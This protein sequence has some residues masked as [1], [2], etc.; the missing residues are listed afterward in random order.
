MRFVPLLGLA[1]QFAI[2]GLCLAQQPCKSTVVGDLRISHFDSKIYGR[3][4]TL[5]IWLPPGYG[6]SGNAAHKYPTLYL[7]DGQT[8]FDDCTAF[9][10]E[11]ELQVDETVTRLVEEHKIPPVIVVGIDSTE[12]RAFEYSPYKDTITDARAPEPIGKQLPSFVA[13][14]VIPFVSSRYRVS[15]S[16]AET[17][18]GGTSLG[19]SAALYA[20][21][22]R[23]DLFGL[24]LIQSPNHLLG[25]GQLL[26]DT[27]L[28][29]RAPD[30][31]VIGV[32]TTELN[33]PGI[34]GYLASL[35]LTRAE[36]EAGEVRM[37]RTLASNLQAAFM[38]H[39]QVKLVVEPGA[40]HRS[41]SWA[42]RIPE[43]ISFLYGD[44]EA[45]Q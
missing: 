4:M 30:R 11:H 9:P 32:G 36:A 41:E 34:D 28:V 37:N 12:H 33:L 10:G 19:G 39:S 42:R 15:D 14:E 13:D 29:A 22:A 17:G 2:S 8:A 44:A 20:S 38:K 25:N 26:R 35:R 16:A 43:A 18:I 3:S 6:D 1:A 40:N 27:A 45:V 24:A 5:R 23:S 7:L 31:I 21:L